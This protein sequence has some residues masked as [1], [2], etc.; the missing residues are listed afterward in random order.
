MRRRNWNR[1]ESP[2]SLASGGSLRSSASGL[3]FLHRPPSA[4]ESPLSV[5]PD[6]GCLAWWCGWDW[7]GPASRRTRTT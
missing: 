1:F 7:K 6:C 5:P 3:R 4:S 2:D